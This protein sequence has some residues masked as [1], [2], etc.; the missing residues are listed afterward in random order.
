M[1]FEF[2]LLLKQQGFSL[3]EVLIAWS[4]S[5]TIM[6]GIL[7]SANESLNNTHHCYLQTLA[8]SRIEEMIE[9]LRVNT[10][11]IHQEHEFAIWNQQNSYLLPKGLG[12]YQ[13][14]NIAKICQIKINWQEKQI[15][16]L[17]LDASVG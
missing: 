15:E 14:N 7:M 11:P 3:L 12:E 13:C 6:L 8:T 2:T 17:Q 5:I 4:L 10:D 1:N 9:R 16:H